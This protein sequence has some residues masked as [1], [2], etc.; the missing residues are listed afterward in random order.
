M[1]DRIRKIVDGLGK[2]T[3]SQKI[4][5]EAT[6]RDSEFRVELDNG[7]I[8]VDSWINYDDQDG[9]E[10]RIADIRFFDKS[11]EVIDMFTFPHYADAQDYRLVSNL[12]N[13]ARRKSLRIDEKIDDIVSEL[14][15][16]INE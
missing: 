10:D 14:F 15:K 1:D 16:K 4:S 5:W 3:E 9:S 13:L 12:Q 8:S 6:S 7:S 11:G 2:A